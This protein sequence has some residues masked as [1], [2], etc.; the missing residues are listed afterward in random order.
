MLQSRFALL[1]L[2]LASIASSATDAQVRERPARQFPGALPG[3]TSPVTNR[4]ALPMA[5]PT[6]L[7]AA[8]TPAMASL[9]WDTVPGAIGYHVSRADPAGGT[10]RLT[11]D[12][13]TATRF[14]DKSGGVK[15]G[16][17]YIYHVTAAYPD[18]AGTADVSFTPPTPAV[19]AWVRIE[20]QGGQRALVWAPVA[21]AGS[22]QITETW[23]VPIYKTVS[24]P[25]YRVGGTTWTTTTVQSGF[26]AVSGTHVVTAPQSSLPIRTDQAGHRFQVGAA[27]P[28][29]GVTAPRDQWPHVP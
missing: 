17:T 26:Q 1:S 28:P 13:T 21:D 27:Y 15:P 5:G 29:S 6:N 24:I 14:E 4:L 2:A 8:G 23:T 16:T 9:R 25:V 11:T 20:P 3:P 18:G 12:P 22:Y 7:T 19:P 10:V